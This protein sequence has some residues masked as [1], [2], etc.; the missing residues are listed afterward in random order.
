MMALPATMIALPAR[1]VVGHSFSGGGGGGHSFSGGGGG[2]H[3]FG[4]GVGGGG[5]GGGIIGL[6][7]IVAIVVAVVLVLRARRG[8][9][10]TGGAPATGT[11]GVQPG[12]WPPPASG[13]NGWSAGGGEAGAAAA[14]GAAATAGN[15]GTAAGPPPRPQAP[16]PGL[17]TTDPPS[18]RSAAT[19]S[20]AAPCRRRPLGRERCRR[21][22]TASAPSSSTIPTSIRGAFLDSAQRAFFV[23]QEAWTDRKPE[24]SRQV[25]LTASGSSTESRSRATRTDKRNI[26]GDLAV[27]NMDIVTAH[28]DS[29]YNTI[30]V[31]I[32]AA[33]SDYDVADDSGKVVRGNKR[34]G[35]WAEDW[36]FQRSSSATTNAAGGTLSQKCPN[37]GAPLNVD[38]AG[39]CPYCKA[40]V[41][42]G[43]YDWVLA[44]ISQ[45]PAYT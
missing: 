20:L 34:V 2:T 18:N 8:R 11:P 43:A 21:S 36:T 45:V 9:R 19:C 26:M 1:A 31:R 30:T 14:A 4:G 10:G 13:Q 16:A 37:C 28:S 17:T 23:V 24:M 41:M 7:V 42:S 39:V 38:L 44:R 25:M 6:I 27:G 5:G 35:E 22:P 3:F 29:S 15:V 32:R 12:E 40:P 33:C